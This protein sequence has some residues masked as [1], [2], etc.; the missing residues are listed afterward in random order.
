MY[1]DSQHREDP[2]SS[3]NSMD[4]LQQLENLPR[5]TKTEPSYDDGRK[6]P[7][8]FSGYPS[9]TQ[10]QNTWNG[11]DP[12]AP[13]G[14]HLHEQQEETHSGAYVNNYP[15]MNESQSTSHHPEIGTS[16]S[17]GLQSPENSRDHSTKIRDILSRYN[18][19]EQQAQQSPA[20]TQSNVQWSSTPYQPPQTRYQNMPTSQATIV[21]QP[22]VTVPQPQQGSAS[23][24]L[25]GQRPNSAPPVQPTVQ[26][27]Q[28]APTQFQPIPQQ[29]QVQ[30]TLV[31]QTPQTLVQQ[32]PQTLVQPQQQQLPQTQQSPKVQAQPQPVPGTFQSYPSLP[33]QW[34]PPAIGTTKQEIKLE[35]VKQQQ[36]TMLLMMD[37]MQQQFNKFMNF[38]EGVDRRLNKLEKA[39][40]EILSQ[41]NSVVTVSYDPTEVLQAAQQMQ[42]EKTDEEL[43]RRLQEEL[44][45]EEPKKTTPTPRPPEKKTEVKKSVSPTM[46]DCPVCGKKFSDLEIDEHVNTC[47]DK[48]PPGEKQGIFGKWWGGKKE[49]PK[50]KTDTK[51]DDKKTSTPTPT[52]VMYTPYAIPATTRNNSSY[53]GQMVPYGYPGGYMMPNGQFVYYPVPQNP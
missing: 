6:D 42:Q 14:Y 10:P 29:Q 33:Q 7:N 9:I 20:P 45:R 11:S 15:K 16:S 37:Q 22:T 3:L 4:A 36:Q 53:P 25:S 17:P 18:A 8:S 5:P 32:T 24:P 34:Q 39:T 12:L 50:T 41:Q 49:D 27:A 21:A 52:P 35:E 19:S 23:I 13:P 1:S 44:N 38:F 40:Q 48:V 46:N 26:N 28:W 43:A 47:L 30:Q 31:Q 2:F 51:K